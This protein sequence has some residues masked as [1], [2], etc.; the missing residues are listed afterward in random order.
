[1]FA[2]SAAGVVESGVVESCVCSEEFRVPVRHRG[3]GRWNG[4]LG[5]RGSDGGSQRENDEEKRMRR[6][7]GEKKAAR[8]IV[9]EKG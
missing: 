5:Q 6:R 7:C 3:E 4:M 1:M 2:V 9:G 8:R